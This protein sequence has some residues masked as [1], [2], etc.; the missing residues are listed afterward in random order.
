MTKRISRP[1]A[2]FLMIVTAYVTYYFHADI[3][4]VLVWT[5]QTIIQPYATLWTNLILALGIG[6]VCFMAGWGFWIVYEEWLR[7]NAEKLG[8]WMLFWAQLLC[9]VWVLVAFQWF[10]ISLFDW[11]CAY[12]VLMTLADMETE[13]RWSKC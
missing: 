10:W 9:G 1:T 11:F 8:F 3:T 13:K 12:V 4:E 7:K 2:I 5:D 6:S